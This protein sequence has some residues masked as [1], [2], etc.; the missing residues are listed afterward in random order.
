MSPLSDLLIMIV[1]PLTH[2]DK[3]HLS[4]IAKSR[5]LTGIQERVV[6]S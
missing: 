5:M 3:L 2:L 6:R 4:G 1:R